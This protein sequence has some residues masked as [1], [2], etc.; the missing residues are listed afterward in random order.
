[1]NN[2]LLNRRL[3]LQQLAFMGLLPL[4]GYTMPVLNAHVPLIT[5][6]ALAKIKSWLK[7]MEDKKTGLLYYMDKGTAHFLSPLT[8]A[9]TAIWANCVDD[10]ILLKKYAQAIVFAQQIMAKTYP[11]LKGALASSYVRHKNGLVAGQYVYACEQLVCISALLK[12]YSHFKEDS[13]LIAAHD[14]A[15]F[16]KRTFLNG[17]ALGAW[18]QP[19]PIPFNYLTTNQA[20]ENTM[21]N[22]VEYL[23]ISAFLEL[24]KHTHE[25][26]W[27]QLYQDALAFY[28]NSQADNGLWFDTFFPNKKTWAWYQTTNVVADNMLRC[29]IASTLVGE[30]KQVDHFLQQ[31]ERHHDKG[32]IMGYLSTIDANN[33][34]I[35]QDKPYYDV[36]A[37]GLLRNLYML[38]G[39]YGLAS[40]CQQTLTLLSD[41]KSGYFWGRYQHDFSPV[42][43]EK[44]VITTLWASANL[45]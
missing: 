33:G 39:N 37:T 16:I 6:P 45:F 17:Y 11:E 35:S 19:F 31:L 10:K 3:F 40:Q 24:Y 8:T 29:A 44:A 27:L 43:K 5:E 14:N 12:A 41:S 4:A 20:F 2:Q 34:F 32:L 36:V 22:G 25:Y 38:R 28:K 23:W 26:I 21:R 30:D 9:K 13:F 42:G 18:N 1:M 15:M 7:S